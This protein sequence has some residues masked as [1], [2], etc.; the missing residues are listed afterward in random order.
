MFEFRTQ[1]LLSGFS[2]RRVSEFT[3]DALVERMTS[4][5]SGE[6]VLE[7]RLGCLS[8]VPG[9]KYKTA[10]KLAVK[11]KVKECNSQ[12]IYFNVQKTSRTSYLILSLFCMEI[13]VPPFIIQVREFR[14]QLF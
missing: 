6:G 8:R 1:M 7:T 12:M 4:V 9:S 10:M 13:Y 3:N 14:S 11:A 5:C 2:L